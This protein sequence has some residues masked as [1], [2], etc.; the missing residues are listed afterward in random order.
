MRFLVLR[1]QRRRLV[2]RDSGGLVTLVT[3][4]LAS[5]LK[6]HT[7]S[8]RGRGASGTVGQWRVF[9]LPLS[10]TVPVH[11]TV[12][13]TRS[14]SERASESLESLARRRAAGPGHRDH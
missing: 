9:A 5:R 8:R 2:T 12:T 13:V 7:G 6:P 10:P 3:V 4:A 11:I 1:A 14:E